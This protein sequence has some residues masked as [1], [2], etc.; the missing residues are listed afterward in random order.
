MR[1]WLIFRWRLVEL[2]ARAVGVRVLV[3]HPSV[4]SLEV[5]WRDQSGQCFAERRSWRRWPRLGESGYT[6]AR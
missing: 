1:G 2:F 4:S 6:L 3:V 5:H